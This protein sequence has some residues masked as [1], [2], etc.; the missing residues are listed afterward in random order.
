MNKPTTTC[1]ICGRGILANTGVIAHHGYQRPGDGYQTKSCMGARY[2]PYEVSCDRIQYAIEAITNYKNDEQKA[3]DG[4][5]ASPP[6]TIIDYD[7]N[8]Y[9]GKTTE[10]KYE[11]P[12]DFVYGGYASIPR[13]YANEYSRRV[14]AFQRTIKAC[15]EQIAYLTDRLQKWVA[16]ATER[17][18]V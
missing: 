6:Q 3:L 16:P 1:Q 15:G 12:A 11:K 13:T 8:Y 2:L 18:L 7:K 10:L 5:L 17:G 14:Y 4:W 9:T